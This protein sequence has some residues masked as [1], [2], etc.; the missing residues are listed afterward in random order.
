MDDTPTLLLAGVAGITL[1]A[2]FFGG[3]WWTVRQGMSSKHPGLWF[4]VSLVL[5][6][7]M[8]LSG[9]YLVGGRDWQRLAMCLLGFALARLIVTCLMRPPSPPQL[10][11]TAG[12]SHAP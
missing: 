1:G 4:A 12:V 7:A 8:I 2:I 10:P 11:Q 5:R 6:V 9:L 3:L